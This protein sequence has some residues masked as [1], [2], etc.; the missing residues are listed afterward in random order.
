MQKVVNRFIQRR[1][2]V[3]DSMNGDK[4]NNKDADKIKLLATIERMFNF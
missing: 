1:T 4:V 3:D 2:R